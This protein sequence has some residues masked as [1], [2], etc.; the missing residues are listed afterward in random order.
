MFT[1]IVKDQNGVIVGTL[2]LNDKTFKSGNTGFFGQ[3]KLTV[4]GQRYQCQAQMVLLKEHTEGET[5]GKPEV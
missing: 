2:V 1:A 3:G 5:G 4:A